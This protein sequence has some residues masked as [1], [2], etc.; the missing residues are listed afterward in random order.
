MFKNIRLF[1][2]EEYIKI[3]NN[4]VTLTVQIEDVKAVKYIDEIMSMEGIDMV[5]TGKADISQSVGVP[6]QTNHPR[7]KEMEDLIIRKALEYGKQPVI[8]TRN[9]KRINELLSAGVKAF[10]VGLDSDIILE[11]FK[12]IVCKLK[13][14]NEVD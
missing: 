12:D 3:A 5:A 11:A 9:K 8:L 6:S 10:M 13:M 1:V 2:L 4:L 7:V 14:Y